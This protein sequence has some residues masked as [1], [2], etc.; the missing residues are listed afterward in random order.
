[1]KEE[2]SY[3]YRCVL[4]YSDLIAIASE[5]KI[6][7]SKCKT[8]YPSIDGIHIMLSE[9]MGFLNT[10]INKIK[11]SG[12]R[13]SNEQNEYETVK[14]NLDFRVRKRAEKILS[15]RSMNIDLVERQLSKCR[16]LLKDIQ[17]E[18]KFSDLPYQLLCG[19]EPTSMLPYFYQDWGNTDQLDRVAN[20]FKDAIDK[21]TTSRTRSVVIG[22]GA[23]GLLKKLS[24]NFETT[25]G[26]ELSLPIHLIAKSMIEGDIIE[27]DLEARPWSLERTNI[28][29]QSNAEAN[30]ADIRYIAADALNLPFPSNSISV[31]V[32]QFITDII[33]APANLA[34]EI[35]R[36]LEPGGIWIDL[37]LPFRVPTDPMLLPNRT[38]EDAGAFLEDNGFEVVSINRQ[39]YTEG[40]TAPVIE[41]GD[42]M[43]RAP[44]FF[45]GRKV[46]KK[47]NNVD[48]FFAYWYRNK[49]PSIWGMCPNHV[50]ERELSILR[51]TTLSRGGKKRPVTAIQIDGRILNLT[52]DLAQGLEA[53]LDL[54]DG[55]NS[56]RKISKNIDISEDELLRFCRILCRVEIIE[57]FTN[58]KIETMKPA[59]ETENAS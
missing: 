29:I 27:Y 53:I 42:Q 24:S 46:P 31:V 4:C 8:K 10:W 54:M 37:S 45:T 16:D 21:H 35:H 49:D 15:G 58:Q 28:S 34:K 7:C 41:W 52:P 44:I 20:L 51:G 43:Q 39:R 38:H 19:W 47:N 23:G 11:I 1:M 59:N 13:F 2:K 6:Q 55:T 18:P 9:P 5:T 22:S 17:Y 30:P 32:T 33:G 40:N 48:N 3:L 25:Y 36:I 26:V 57:I 50:S 56:I 14:D 12:D